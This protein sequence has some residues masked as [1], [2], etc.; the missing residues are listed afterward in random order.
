MRDGKDAGMKQKRVLLTR[1]GGPEVLEIVEREVPEPGPGEARVRVLATGVAFADV[2][3]RRGLYPGVPDFPF[4]P[5]Y[6]LVGEVEDLGP[7]VSGVALGQRVAALTQVGAHA[8]YVALP[9]GELV[10]VPAGVDAAEAASLPVNYVTAHQMLFRVTK[11]KPGER[12][13]VHGA[14]GGVG[15]ALLQLG[16]LQGLEMYGTAS[17]GKHDLVSGLGATPIDYKAEDFVG[18]V[19]ALT[20]DGV[21]AVFDHVG[22]AHVARSF[23]TLRRGGRLVWYGLSAGLAGGSATILGAT[24]L[25]RIALWNALPNG[26]RA[27]FYNTVYTLKERHPEWFREDL[28]LLLGLLAEGRVRPVVAERLP[29][30]A[31]AQRLGRLR[32]EAA[33]VPSPVG[34]GDHRKR[35]HGPAWRENHATSWVQE[36]PRSGWV[37][38]I[39]FCHRRDGYV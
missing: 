13:L 37:R 28:A 24:T 6:D 25:G 9:A 14:A 11:V 30:R 31:P 23:R 3:M 10:P 34:E 21:D 29:L 33:P 8:Q 2:M 20:G 1:K 12:I 18:R 16:G 26:R 38:R 4:T 36:P 15:T 39:T 32:R 7:G 27:A 35:R 19:R 17:A 22:G 5:G